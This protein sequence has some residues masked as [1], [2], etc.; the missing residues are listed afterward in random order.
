MADY[1]EE[2][3]DAKAEELPSDEEGDEMTKI[4]ITIIVNHHLPF[5]LFLM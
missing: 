1:F 3:E 2:D 5:W 4:I